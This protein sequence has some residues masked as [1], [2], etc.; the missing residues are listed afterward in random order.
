[1]SVVSSTLESRA[2]KTF[3]GKRRPQGRPDPRAVAEELVR[4]GVMHDYFLYEKQGEARIAGDCL[5]KVTVASDRVSLEWEGVQL[6]SEPAG[7]P[8]KQVESLLHSLP[9]PHWTAFGYAAFDLAKYYQAAASAVLRP[10]VRGPD[11][12]WRGEPPWRR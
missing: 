2:F 12:P 1:M 8:F 7:D 4:A 11:R 5:A 6:H 9:I 3:H 10:Q